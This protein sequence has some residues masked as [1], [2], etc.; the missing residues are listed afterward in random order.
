MIT[1][2]HR[3]CSIERSHIARLIEIGEETALSPWSAESY[4][5]EMCRPDSIML[6]LVSDENET[7]GFVV[8][9][10]IS[11][12]TTDIVAESE[13]YN[14]AVTPANRGKGNGQL[15]LDAFID[16]ARKKGARMVWLEVR[17][18]NSTAIAFYGRNGFER[19]DTRPNFYKDPREAALL[20]RLKLDR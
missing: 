1:S 3:I 19:L 11:A 9:R 12:G 7:I 6:R 17:E 18:S 20:M 8:G 15:L 14:I 4:L 16:A 2:S 5:A 10:I 13:I